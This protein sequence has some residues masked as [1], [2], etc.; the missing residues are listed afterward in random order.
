MKTWW[1]IAVLVSVLLPDRIFSQRERQFVFPDDSI[2]FQLSSTPAQKQLVGSRVLFESN[3]SSPIPS[4]IDRLVF[5]GISAQRTWLLEISMS[6]DTVQWSPWKSIEIHWYPENQFWAR[7]MIPENYRD[8][9]VKY[10]IVDGGIQGELAIQF[11]SIE[12]IQSQITPEIVTQE[13]VPFLPESKDS[14]ASPPLVTRAEWGA[15]PHNG[16]LVPHIPYRASIHHTSIRRVTTLQEGFNELR[17]IQDLHMIA[18]GWKDIGYHYCIDDSGRIY[19]GA[20]VRYLASHTDNNNS[21]NVGIS[22]LGNF[23]TVPPTQ[24]MLQSCSDLLAYLETRFPMKTDSIFGHRDYDPLTVCP[25]ASAYALLPDIRNRVRLKLAQG[26][27]YIKNPLPIP[28]G[29]G[30]DPASSIVFRLRDELEGIQNDSIVVLINSVIVQPTIQV[31]DANEVLIT[32]TPSLPFA[33]SSLVSVDIKAQDRAVPPSKLTYHYQFKIKAQSVLVEMLSENI[34]SN[35][36]WTKTGS[37]MIST[38]DAVMP[39]LTDGVMMSA[40]DSMQNHNVVINPNIQESGNY[41]VYLVLPTQALGLNARYVV[42]NSHGISKEEFIEYNRNFDK[43]WFQLGTSAVYF[44]AGSP[45]NG[46]IQIQ[47]MPGFTTAMMLDAIKLEKKDPQI[48]PAI[49]E[50]KSVR[51]LPWG[52]IQI[53]WYPSLEGG[54]RGYRIMK[55]T[56]GNSW[57]DT[58]VNENI[59]GPN[60]TSYTFSPL[61]GKG[62][63]YFQLFAV[64][65]QQTVNIEGKPDFV[66]SQPS[67]VYGTTYGTNRTV[68]IVDAFDRIGSWPQGQHPFARNYGNAITTQDVG[69]ETAVNDAI[70][71][72]EIKVEDYFIVMYMCGDDSDREEALS[73]IELL[74]IKQYLERGGKLFISGSEIGYDLGRSG[75]PDI[76]LYNTIFKAL[77]AGDDSGVRSCTGSSGSLF[78]GI[79]FTFGAATEDTYLEDFP[80][81]ITPYNGSQTVLLYQNTTKVAGISFIGLFTPESSLPCRLIY[82]AFPFETIYPFQSRISV[83]DKILGYFLVMDVENDKF[84]SLPTIFNLHQNYPNPFNPTTTI[85]YELPKSSLVTLKVFDLLGREVATLVNEQ[86]S[87]GRYSVTWDAS[88]MASGIYFYKINAGEFRE[89]KRLILLK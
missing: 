56:D 55:S 20:D 15:V 29:T 35:A 58:L 74:R 45:S 49:P 1:M 63:L 41:F 75:R 83:M 57:L 89:A 44:S 66:M 85:R 80:D 18:N 7:L 53:Q 13:N 51:L 43:T 2:F 31:I 11:F 37:W 33:Y 67:D 16:V 38:A 61:S 32:Y 9:A 36:Q 64:D 14:I 59:V 47:P 21:G 25:G 69:W 46:S 39:E 86:K 48:P 26:A 78:D 81:Y 70:Q 17:Y 52:K 4:A 79:T 84:A 40:Q 68:L 24:M 12:F 76:A 34:L 50:L 19:E 71:S 87:T 77:Y 6:Q 54:L 5:A 8:G 82:F 72:G 88:S 10:R 3:L 42:Q 60:D 23:S 22:F 73:N 28:F 27:P 62:A 30:I 65:T